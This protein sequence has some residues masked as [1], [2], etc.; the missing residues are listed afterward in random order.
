MRETRHV[1]NRVEAINEKG[2]SC[3]A[4]ALTPSKMTPPSST[5]PNLHMK[6]LCAW[7]VDQFETVAQVRS[8]LTNDVQLWG[9]GV[10]GAD[11]T[12]WVFRDATGQ[13]LVVEKKQLSTWRFLSPLD[14]PEWRVC[15][16]F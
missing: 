15:K 2:L 5:K 1:A 11:Y 3:G 6:Y 16:I 12:H 13:S 4:L 10:S 8:A 9:H 7:S 14:E